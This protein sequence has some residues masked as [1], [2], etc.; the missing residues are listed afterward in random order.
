MKE[1]V[2]EYFH[3]VDEV[4]FEKY[5]TK[6]L[7]KY[8]NLTGITRSDIKVWYFHGPDS[9]KVIVRTAMNAHEE[10][11]FTWLSPESWSIQTLDYYLEQ[12]E[13]EKKFN[14]QC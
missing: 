14:E 9:I 3:S 13:R 12:I 11:I 2:M 5:D 4:I 6:L 8:I 7:D 10:Y 1:E